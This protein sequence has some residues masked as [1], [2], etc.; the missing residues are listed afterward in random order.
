MNQQMNVV[1]RNDVAQSDIAGSKIFNRSGRGYVK[2][3][4][5]PMFL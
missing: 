4:Q 1:R 5:T 3:E 2:P